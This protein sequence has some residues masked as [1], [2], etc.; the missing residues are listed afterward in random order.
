MSFFKTG[1]TYLVSNIVNAAIPFMLLPILTRYLTQEEYGQIAMFQLLVAALSAVAGLGVVGASARKYYDQDITH[2]QLKDFNGACFQILFIST[3]II[4]PFILFF[5]KEL[6]VLLAIPADW[7]FISLTIA[8]LGFI[9]QIRLSQWQ[10]RNQA[11]QYGSLQIVNSL[12]NVLFSLLLV[13]TLNL[14]PSGRVDAQLI[15]VLI[16]GLLSLYYLK[17]DN[18]VNFFSFKLIYIREALNFGLPLMPHIIGIFILSSFDRYIINKELGLESAAIY[19]VSYQLSS[20]LGIVF[21]AINK[22]YVPWLYALLKKD[23]EKDK[24]KIVKGTY[25]YMV[26]LLILAMLSFILGPPVVIF[27][28]GEKYAQAG[29]IIGYL[30]AGQIFGGMYL[31][32][33]NY[34]FYSK[35]TEYLSLVTIMSGAISVAL[36]LTLIQYNGLIGVAQAF[37]ISQFIR[38]LSTWLL[39]AKVQPMP[40]SLHKA[41]NNEKINL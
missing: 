29:S 22:A 37:A 38:F 8:S 30:C 13:I 41:R 40:W 3:L 4:S 35:K 20:A 1:T 32:V 24:L 34:I 27:I 5:Y 23:A 16:M 19:M 39:S 15:T 33:A 7:I 21:D 25:L 18:L 12:I 36:M 28:A 10:I 14:G 26:V 6:S 9:L 31:M 11:K 2:D 17:Q